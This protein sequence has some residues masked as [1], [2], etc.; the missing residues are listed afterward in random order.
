VLSYHS[1]SLVP[2]NTPYVA[3][4]RDLTRFLDRLDSYL[5]FFMGVLGG[6]PATPDE[7][8]ELASS[9]LPGAGLMAAGPPPLGRSAAI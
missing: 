4:A 9:A 8:R 3:T 7:I 1:S 2:G 5:A 6:Q